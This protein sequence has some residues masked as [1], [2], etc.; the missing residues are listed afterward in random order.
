MPH[1][2]TP[3]T[4]RDW[5]DVS[6]LAK[7]IYR[8]SVSDH[9]GVC[10]I[11]AVWR[12][13]HG[14]HRILRLTANTPE[15]AY[16]R[17]VLGLCRARADAILTTGRIL[18]SEPGL[19]HDYLGPSTLRHALAEWRLQSLGKTESV[20]SV[21]LTSGEQLPRSHPLFQ[22]RTRPV[23]VTSSEGARRLGAWAA[24][25]AVHVVT[26][27]E[28]SAAQALRFVRESLGA[29]TISI[30]AGPHTALP[31]YQSPSLV[32]ELW[33]SVYLSPT[34]ATSVVGPA[35]LDPASLDAAFTGHTQPFEVDEP[36]GPWQFHRFTRISQ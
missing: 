34:V 15:G 36:S 32:D 30:E 27:A 14:G 19:T 3:D 9:T 29:R 13:P 11:A 10:H 35:F 28:P 26:M 21:I 2:L 16:D 1:P 33:L 8:S 17:F 24:A 18:R 5:Q 31:L 12:D 7:V 6:T 4:V 23:I 25:A 22:G 20:R